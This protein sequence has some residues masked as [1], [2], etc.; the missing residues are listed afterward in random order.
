MLARTT[1]RWRRAE[2]AAATA[3]TAAQ[4]RSVSARARRLESRPAERLAR[5]GE[6]Q[7]AAPPICKEFWSHLD[8]HGLLP[9]PNDRKQFLEA[10]RR[11]PRVAI[12]ANP[13]KIDTSISTWTSSLEKRRQ[14]RFSP[15]PW[16][17]LGFFVD[18]GQGAVGNV[19]EHALGEFFVQEATSMLPAEV[20]WG[21]LKKSPSR[22]NLEHTAVLDLCAAP[23]GKTTHLAALM[24]GKGL[25]V[26][27]DASAA[28][29]RALRANLVVAG[30][31]N[32]IVENADGTD[33]GERF[34]RCFDGVLVD[35]P[36]TGMGTVRKN[37]S[38]LRQWPG[39][40][41]EEAVVR[42]MS[43]LRAGW[44]SL[45]PGGALVYSTCSL[46]W[47]ENEGLIQAFLQEH[48]G[49]AAIADISW[50]LGAPSALGWQGTLRI[51]PHVR[52]TDGFF[53]AALRK[54]NVGVSA[55]SGD[56]RPKRLG[57][58]D[59]SP[60]LLECLAYPEGFSKAS[61]EEASMCQE[62]LR[63]E[64]GAGLL[65]VVAGVELHVRAGGRRELWLL[66]PALSA[67]RSRGPAPFSPGIVVGRMHAGGFHRSAEFSLFA[68]RSGSAAK[69]WTAAGALTQRLLAC[70]EGDVQDFNAV[71]NASAEEPTLGL[72]GCEQW[73]R[74]L[75]SARVAP[76]GATYGSLIKAAV[77]EG[78]S[79]SAIAWFDR[80]E[81]AGVSGDVVKYTMV[82]DACARAG[83]TALAERWL[84][85]MCHKG[86]RPNV[87]VFAALLKAFARLGD[88]PRA[89]LWLR[90]MD[91]TGVRANGPCY[92]AVLRAHIT[93][94][95]VAGAKSIL[96]RMQLEG[97]QLEGVV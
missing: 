4:R 7:L 1:G 23:G 47:D 64:F 21:C 41:L 69:S 9:S 72:Q 62:A 89:D 94:E 27:N 36:C 25:I 6:G 85:R 95:D 81:A 83:D 14:W 5:V 40:F 10:C 52:D 91:C 34:P 49:E 20:L 68:A 74:R 29:C 50:L 71:L 78:A 35:A 75:S 96:D 90:R 61:V 15:V 17:S 60:P 16:S 55:G 3:A 42:Q 8:E 48:S 38:V 77:R 59:W 39:D 13:L 73:M 82:C 28:R 65:D 87:V 76:D 45:R 12:R 24:G 33:F 43:L 31:K 32:A 2:R 70:L 22:R 51:W 79:S 18:S 86:V 58:T 19:V 63:A 93:A 57:D 56:P 44:L 67:A 11:P 54:L 80:M 92:N 37:R 97:M 88:A 53:V 66:P 26:A 30:V 46:S 84:L